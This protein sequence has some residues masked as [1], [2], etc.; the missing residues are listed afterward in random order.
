[1]INLTKPNLNQVPS[2]EK[3]VRLFEKIM[4][5]GKGQETLIEKKIFV[6]NFL[7]TVLLN[8]HFILYFKA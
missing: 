3:H 8:E 4:Y 5:Q 2:Q 1:M 6:E 7:D